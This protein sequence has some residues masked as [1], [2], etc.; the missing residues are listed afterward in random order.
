MPNILIL[1]ESEFSA[2][3]NLINDLGYRFMYVQREEDISL[4]LNSTSIDLLILS[5]I[6]TSFS[7]LSVVRL[8]QAILDRTHDE[9]SPLAVLLLPDKNTWHPLME[10]W[11]RLTS[12]GIPTD[13]ATLPAEAEEIR[14][15][16]DA[17]MQKQ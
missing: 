3:T 5:P 15:R 4:A 10:L 11:Q 1:F 13:Y 12:H 2:L 6:N 9:L 8:F 14:L 7:T 17:L 16:L